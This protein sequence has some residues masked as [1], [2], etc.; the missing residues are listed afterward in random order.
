MRNE[1]NSVEIKFYCLTFY[2]FFVGVCVV[3]NAYFVGA[4]GFFLAKV[5]LS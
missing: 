3:V 1:L 5:E 2:L 4:L